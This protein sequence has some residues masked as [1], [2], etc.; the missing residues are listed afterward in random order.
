M[1]SAISWPRFVSSVT[2]SAAARPTTRCVMLSLC[3]LGSTMF[4]GA[5]TIILRGARSRRCCTSAGLKD[6]MHPVFSP[7]DPPRTLNMKPLPPPFRLEA[8]NLRRTGELQIAPRFATFF[9]LFSHASF[10]CEWPSTAQ[11]TARL[12]RQLLQMATC[13]SALVLG[14]LQRWD[15]ELKTLCSRRGT[16]HR[17]NVKCW[18]CRTLEISGN[19]EG[20]IISQKQASCTIQCFSFFSWPP[21]LRCRM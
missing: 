21:V 16:F 11:T 2:R 14:I 6:Q 17:L 8:Y 10:G 15:S 13:W 5:M 20:H 7:W 12:T 3:C 18:R 9:H 4:R 1:I 19:Q